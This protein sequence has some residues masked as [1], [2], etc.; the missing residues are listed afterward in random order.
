VLENSENKLEAL[1]EML[2]HGEVSGITEYN[3]NDFLA[4]LDE[5][6]HLSV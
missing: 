6:K 3:Y 4:E 2:I 5:E 1:R